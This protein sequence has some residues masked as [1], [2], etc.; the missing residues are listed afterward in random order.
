LRRKQSQHERSKLAS[1]CT[2]QKIADTIDPRRSDVRDTCLYSRDRKNL[3]AGWTSAKGEDVEL[4][5]GLVPAE[6][7]MEARIARLE[8]DVSHLRSDVADIKT[9]VRALRDKV[10]GLGLRHDAKIDGL[11]DSIVAAQSW[12]IVLYI[13]LAAGTFGTLARAFGWI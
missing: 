4:N 8:S 2:P 12:A 5:A 13:A 9:D 1:Q 10:D 11:K 6:G 3:S 7:L